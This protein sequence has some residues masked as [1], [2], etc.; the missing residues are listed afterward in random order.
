MTRTAS[1]HAWI[2]ALAVSALALAGCSGYQLQGKVIEGTVSSVSVVDAEDPRLDQIGIEDARVQVTLDP[3]KPARQR[4]PLVRS[5]GD[6]S[7]AVPVDE[8][9]AGMLQYDVEVRGEAAGFRGA[10][11]QFPLPGRSKRVLIQ[12]APGQGGRRGPAPG[13]DDF[14]GETLRMSEPYMEGR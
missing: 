9:G 7:F 5:R 11:E 13:Q 6:G 2:G 14:L 1:M 3:L 12:L 4:L 10:V 8:V